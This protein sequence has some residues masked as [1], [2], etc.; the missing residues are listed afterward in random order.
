[1]EYGRECVKLSTLFIYILFIISHYLILKR[2]RNIEIKNKGQEVNGIS[3]I[4][5]SR[6]REMQAAW[7]SLHTC[8]P[9]W[10]TLREILEGRYQGSMYERLAHLPVVKVC[11]GRYLYPPSPNGETG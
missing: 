1:M 11:Q 3:W 8:D 6:V 9:K 7:V 4:E 5:G 2:R 10:V